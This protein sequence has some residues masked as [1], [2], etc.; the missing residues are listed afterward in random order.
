MGGDC[1]QKV[2]LPEGNRTS[3]G[4][5]VD[6]RFSTKSIT[7]SQRSDARRP[8]SPVSSFS[9]ARWASTFVAQTT[10]LDTRRGA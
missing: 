2:L 3:I 1:S 8:V 10:H 7:L 4:G 6:L 5:A 9:A